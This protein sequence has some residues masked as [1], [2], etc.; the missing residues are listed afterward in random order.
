MAW[1]SGPEA[2]FGEDEVAAARAAGLTVCGLGAAILR[3][4]TAALVAV[5]L[6][7]AAGGALDGA[8]G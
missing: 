6:A 1:W 3:A 5:T 4:E 7:L 8:A 2:G